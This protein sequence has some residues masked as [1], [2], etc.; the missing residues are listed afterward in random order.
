LL[1]IIPKAS[2]GEARYRMTK[3]KWRIFGGF[4][5]AAIIVASLM[6]PP[7]LEQLRTGHFA[8]EHFLAYFAAMCVVCRG[9]PRPFLVAGA[10]VVLAALLEA[11]QTLDPDHNLSVLAALSSMAGVAT[12]VPLA[13][14][15]SRPAEM[16][17]SSKLTNA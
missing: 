16:N 17:V 9:W 8:I 1:Q 2:R 10:L 5:L 4:T 14:F 3:S 15:L 7:G 11:L 13:I 12:A 6:L